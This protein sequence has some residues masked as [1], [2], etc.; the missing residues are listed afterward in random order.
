MLELVGLKIIEMNRLM[1]FRGV[2]EK[3]F[4]SILR[5][6]LVWKPKARFADPEFLAR[7]YPD[8]ERDGIFKKDPTLKHKLQSGPYIAAGLRLQHGFES[9][10]SKQQCIDNLE[11]YAALGGDGGLTEDSMRLACGLKARERQQNQTLMDVGIAAIQEDSQE[12]LVEVD[13]AMEMSTVK[14]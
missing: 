1:R 4:P 7:H 9:K 8:H 12:A 13:N 6:S 10:T 3:N 14:S 2:T 11:K 5:R